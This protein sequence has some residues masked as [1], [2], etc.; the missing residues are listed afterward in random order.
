MEDTLLT[1]P[2]TAVHEKLGARLVPFAGYAMPVQYAGLKI[3][4]AAVREQAGLFDVSHMGEL[5]FEGSGAE[6]FLQRLLAGNLA[7][8]SPGRCLYT[9]LLNERGGIV[10]DLLVYGLAPERFMLVVN[11]ANRAEVV[12]L[13]EA[14]LKVDPAADDLSWEDRSDST[15]LIALQGPASDKVIEQVVPGAEKL[16]F[17]ENAEFE[18]QAFG[19]IIV[20]AT[21]YTGERGFEIYTDSDATQGM[22][23]ALMAAGAAHGLIPAGLGARDTLRLE[24]GYC[25][26]GQDIGPDRTPVEAGLGWTVGWKTE[27]HGKASVLAQKEAGAVV[28]RVGIKL[29][30]RG[31]PRA[32]YQVVNAAG[33]I[34]GEMT[35]GTQSPSLNAPIGMAYVQT[36][37]AKVGTELAVR[38][39]NK[40]IAA[41]ISKVPFV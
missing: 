30:E 31:I 25:L 29:V 1:T 8:A 24:K 37:H 33:E 18:R 12:E 27:F 35:S 32:G 10:E 7:K 22:W 4:H 36:V 41:V 17:Y 3:E 23:H 38:I 20:S 34:V 39:R 9:V 28:K 11:A 14:R 13:I 19:K 15:G 5:H 2:L 26:H 16:A 40:D 6:P 21:G